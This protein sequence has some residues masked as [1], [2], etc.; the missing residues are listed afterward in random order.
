[1]CDEPTG[2]CGDQLVLSL[3]PG[4]TFELANTQQV[5]EHCPLHCVKTS[6]V[7]T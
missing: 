7:G 3:L 1:M 2:I 6:P 5:T 4:K